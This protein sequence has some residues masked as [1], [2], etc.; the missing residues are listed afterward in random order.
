MR[1]ARFIT[2]EGPEGSGKS[3]HSRLLT[4][5][6]RKK[7]Y[8]VIR[9]REPGGTNISEDVRKILLSPKNRDISILCELFLY[10]ASRAQLVKD[11]I[12][13]AL[14]KGKFVI[15]DRFSDSTLA[16]QGYGAGL[17]L[18]FVK[19]LCKTAS[20]NIEPCLTIL[21]D[22]SPKEGLDRAGRIK[23]R[24]EKKSI[25]FHNRVRQGYLKIA[26]QNPKR[27]KI[28]SS[29][30][31]DISEVQEKIRYFVEKIAK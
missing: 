24:L 3:T 20:S 12:I 30:G 21:L 25:A 15:C 14:K 16:Y 9:L 7:G 19:R 17:D 13:P 28:F 18:G 27:I 11:V 4:A 5:Y 29:L 2:F 31:S 10:L 26:R 23:D 22:V 1:Y 6:L 8:K